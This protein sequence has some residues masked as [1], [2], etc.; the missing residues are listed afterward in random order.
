MGAATADPNAAIFRRPDMVGSDFAVARG[1]GGARVAVAGLAFRCEVFTDPSR[2][3]APPSA[4]GRPWT[5]VD[6]RL[7]DGPAFLLGFDVEPGTPSPSMPTYES[8]EAV[9]VIRDHALFDSLARYLRREDQPPTPL[10]PVPRPLPGRLGLLHR[11][12]TRNADGSF[13]PGGT[14]T[15]AKLT[16]VVEVPELYAEIYVNFDPANG[17]GELSEKEPEYRPDLMQLLHWSMAG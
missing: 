6:A 16:L 5:F 4:S 8:A 10:A 2:A 12:A 11:A 7:D 17:R 15:C 9:V 3:Y 14:W 1:E 13:S